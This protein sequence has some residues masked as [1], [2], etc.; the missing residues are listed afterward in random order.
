MGKQHQARRSRVVVVPSTDA[1]RDV[2]ESEGVPLAAALALATEQDI[3]R[4]RTIL[5]RDALGLS[6]TEVADA[7]RQ[8]ETHAQLIVEM[9][10]ALRG[11]E[12]SK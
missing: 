5:G 1:R 7:C 10:L 6:D 9:F 3:T 12:R 11:Q 4:A 2:P 8:A